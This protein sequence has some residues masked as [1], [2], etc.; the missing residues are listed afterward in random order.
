MHLVTVA[1]AA[2]IALFAAADAAAVPPSPSSS[3]EGIIRLP[4]IRNENGQWASLKRG[5]LSKRA[6]KAS[7]YN[8]FGREYMLEVGIGTPA[9]RFNLTLDTGSAELWVPSTTCSATEC[10]YERFDTSKSSTYKSS[11]E[12]FSVEYGIGKAS[13]VYVHETVTVGSSKVTSQKVALVSS[14]QE[15]LGVVDS[16]EQANG[17][18]GLGYPG[19]NTVRGVSNDIPFVFNLAKSLKQPVFSIF[20]N[21][22]FAYG[23]SGEIMF[24][25]IDPSKFSGSLKYVPV[26]KYDTSSYLVSPVLNKKK[27]SDSMYLY[28]TVAGQGVKA[29]GYS[30]SLPRLEGFILDTGTTLTMIPRRYADGIISAVAGPGKYA[31]DE[32]NGVYRVDCSIAKDPKSVD[33]EISTSTTSKSSEPVVISTPLSQ[34]VIPLDTDYLESAT[35]CMFGI[36]VSGDGLTDGETWIIGEASL[37]SMYTAYNVEKNTV[38]LAP[39]KYAGAHAPAPAPAPPATTTTTTV[40]SH[41]TTSGLSGHVPTTTVSLP[42]AAA[43]TTSATVTPHHAADGSSG[44]PP[45]PVDQANGNVNTDPAVSSDTTQPSPDADADAAAAAAA[46]AASSVASSSIN[47]PLP[48]DQVDAKMKAMNDQGSGASHTF[49]T[50]MLLGTTALAAYILL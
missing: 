30:A 25:G 21:S 12:K 14:T 50:Q 8:A 2:L 46:A 16:G 33:F 18:M 45:P 36:S 38:G 42:A 27:S 11:A 10:P 6:E 48:T 43:A 37:R 31:W 3:Q 23:T 35:T 29:T 26:A 24:G 32:S 7:L 44:S 4:L 40:P 34:L 9:Q 19:L 49:V 15:I 17:I 1:S 13:G 22:M 39:A 28:W 47:S 5:G 20:L 41:S